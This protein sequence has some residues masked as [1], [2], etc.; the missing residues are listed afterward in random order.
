MLIALAPPK[1]YADYHFLEAMIVI[2]F[3]FDQSQKRYY[4]GYDARLQHIDLT[5]YQCFYN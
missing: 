3:Y 2:I 4:E 5:K 1:V